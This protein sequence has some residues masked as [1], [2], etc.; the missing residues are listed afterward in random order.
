MV[1]SEKGSYNNK[2]GIAWEKNYDE[3]KRYV[4]MPERGT[5]LHT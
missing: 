3:F 1:A 5:P 4:E 2:M